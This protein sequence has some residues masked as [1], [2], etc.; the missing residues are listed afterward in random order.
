MA[1]LR[2]HW[3]IRIVRGHRVRHGRLQLLWLLG[4]PLQLTLT[5]SRASHSGITSQACHGVG[6]PHHCETSRHRR[7]P[8]GLNTVMAERIVDGLATIQIHE[9]Q[10]QITAT[11]V[12]SL[13]WQIG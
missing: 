5:L 12:R 2:I 13:Q 6:V 8:Q 7:L 1:G 11:A 3:Q 4:F 10:L 9:H